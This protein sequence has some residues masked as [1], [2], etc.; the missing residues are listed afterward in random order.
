MIQTTLPE[1][2]AL[3]VLNDEVNRC[4][5]LIPQVPAE[6]DLHKLPHRA[7]SGSADQKITTQVS[8]QIYGENKTASRQQALAANT[9]T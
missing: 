3:R 4:R 9:Y 7:W 1:R 8:Q 6:I 5:D 2:P